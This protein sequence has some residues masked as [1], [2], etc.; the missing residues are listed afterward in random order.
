MSVNGRFAPLLLGALAIS[1]SISGLGCGSATLK[2]DGGTGVSGQAGASGT[3]GRAG[4]GGA[5]AGGIGGG[6]AG[7]PCV[8]DSTPV[9]NCILR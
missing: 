2:T 3:A 8:L 7:P 9:N 6:V 5:G 4:A 1:L